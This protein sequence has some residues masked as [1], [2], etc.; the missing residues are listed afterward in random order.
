MVRV[1]IILLIMNDLS[2]NRIGDENFMFKERLQKRRSFMEQYYERDLHF[3]L[4]YCLVAL[5]LARK[6]RC[7]LDSSSKQMFSNGLGLG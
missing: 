5:F 7:E 6:T 4:A 2:L 3:E 1:V